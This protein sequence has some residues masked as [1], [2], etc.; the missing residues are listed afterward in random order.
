VSREFATVAPS[1]DPL[2]TR[3]WIDGTLA[4]RADVVVLEGTPDGAYLLRYTVNGTFVGDTWHMT[5]DDARHQATYEF[6]EAL[7]P[8]VAIPDSVG[9]AAAF[10]LLQIEGYPT[11]ALATMT[12]AGVHR[13]LATDD[14]VVLERLARAAGATRWYRV[15][16][17]ED[18]AA[19]ASRVRPGSLVSFYFDDRIANSLVSQAVREHVTAIAAS[20]HDAVV[21]ARGADIDL[22]ADFVSDSAELEE[23][24][25]S[26]A[27]G[28]LLFYGVSPAADDDGHAAITVV[29]PDADGVLRSHPY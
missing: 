26:L 24:L 18:L 6:G 12:S 3:H 22:R 9:D 16:T 8:W 5:V 15:A 13:R 27:P 21:A 29:L 14:A 11:L 19:L 17:T 10:A 2:K 25:G 28:E 20:D 1:T 7:H 23:F 4:S